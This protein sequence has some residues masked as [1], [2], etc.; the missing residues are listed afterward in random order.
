MDEGEDVLNK[1]SSHVALILAGEGQQGCE[2]ICNDR[3]WLHAASD[4][5]F[6]AEGLSS[7]GSIRRR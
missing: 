3:Y 2:A 4:E 1:T 7:V 6:A 5:G